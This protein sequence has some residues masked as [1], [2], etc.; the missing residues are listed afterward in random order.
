MSSDTHPSDADATRNL[1]VEVRARVESP[2]ASICSAVEADLGSD[3]RCMASVFVSDTVS[4][5]S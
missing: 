2:N 4:P 5:N 1:G 3:H